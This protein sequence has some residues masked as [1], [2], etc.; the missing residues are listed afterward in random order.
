MN[1]VTDA[2]P[3][4]ALAILQRLDLLAKLFEDV[5]VPTAVFQ[6]ATR[7]EKPLAEAIYNY[8]QRKVV[9]VEN[10][11]AVQVLAQDVDLGEAEAIVLALERG[12]ADILI[13]D[14]KGRRV[15]Q[16]HGLYPIGTI[17]VL[18]QAK[19]SGFVGEIKPLLDKLLANRIRI[20]NQLCQQALYLAGE[21]E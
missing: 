15:A 18:L 21:S 10:R 4:I 12:L 5:F 16:L 3:L 11:L 20:S 2:S 17:G 9:T 1:I 8:L 14:A 6:E 7:Q 19:Q 13:D